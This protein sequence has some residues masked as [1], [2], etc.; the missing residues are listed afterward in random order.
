MR[1]LIDIGHPAHVH[2]FKNF[3]WIMEK[4][5]H[6]ILFTTRDKEVAIQLLKA[7]GF[8]FISFGEPYKNIKGKLFGL[9]KFNSLMLKEALKFKPDIFIS[10]GSMYAAQV[11]WLLRKPHISLEDTGNLEQIRLYKPFT[12]YILTSDIF[13]QDYGKKQIRYTGYHE[14]A[15]LHPNYYKP[16]DSV[17]KFLGLNK[18]EKFVILRFVSWKATHDIGHKGLSLEIKKRTVNELSRYANVFITS[19]AELSEDLRKYQITI[20]PEKIH[21]ALSFAT[22][23]YG[24]SATMASEAA[25]LGTPAIFLDNDGRGYT[26]EEERKYGLVFNYTESLKDQD[27]S[28]QKAIELLQ[29]PNLKQ[30]WQKRRQKMLSE[31]IDVT[32]FMV[33][34]IENYPES[35]KIMKENPDYQWNFR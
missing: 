35:A 29:L 4:K 14:L 24:E 27:K 10:H 23:L 18:S 25:V 31:K 11:S 9:L 22:L 16:D 28:I 15:Y 13:G 8:D 33:W 20:P 6:K 5:G 1:I 21:D 7:Y 12:K 32:A 19:E 30:E 26:D 2:L 34:F 3:A 17:F